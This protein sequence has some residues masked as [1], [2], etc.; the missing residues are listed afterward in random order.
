MKDN[1]KKEEVKTI[2]ATEKILPA[3]KL[4]FSTQTFRITL[5]LNRSLLTDCYVFP[6]KRIH[7]QHF[8]KLQEITSA[9]HITS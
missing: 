8:N 5:F 2:T 9:N 6:K 4:V 3:Y 1:I 7:I